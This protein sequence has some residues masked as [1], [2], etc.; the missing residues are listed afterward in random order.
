MLTAFG[1]LNGK[2]PSRDELVNEGIRLLFTNVYND[3]CGRSDCNDL[4]R[5]MMEESI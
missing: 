5:K 4:L 2:A 3:Y 1:I